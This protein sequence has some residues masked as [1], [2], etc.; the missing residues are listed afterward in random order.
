MSDNSS[1]VAEGEH[2]RPLIRY[3]KTNQRCENAMVRARWCQVRV[4][5]TASGRLHFHAVEIPV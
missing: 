1:K 3:P 5:G 4:A 2:K